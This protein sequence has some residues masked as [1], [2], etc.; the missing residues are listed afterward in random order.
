[1]P[2][3]PGACHLEPGGSGMA[4]TTPPAESMKPVTSASEKK[5]A[6]CLRG[7]LTTPIT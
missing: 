5:F 6:T 7:R 3:M 4:K 2:V 1:M